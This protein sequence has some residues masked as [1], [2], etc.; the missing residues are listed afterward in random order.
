MNNGLSVKE[1]EFLKRKEK[2]NKSFKKEL[3][4]LINRYNMENSSNT[5]DFILAEYLMGCLEN[6]NKSV[7]KRRNWAGELFYD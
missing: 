4:N 2:N 1:I 3:E 7:K 5:P 6:F